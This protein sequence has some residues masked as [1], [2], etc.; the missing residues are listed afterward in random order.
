[1]ALS[2]VSY[3]HPQ[4]KKIIE[5]LKFGFVEENAE[6]LARFLVKKL[7][8]EK[9]INWQEYLFIPIPLH[10]KRKN[11]RGF[12]QTELLLYNV[13]KIM[14]EITFVDILERAK[15]TKQQALLDKTKR[16]KNLREAF[17]LKPVFFGEKIVLVDDVITTGETIL[18]AVKIFREKGVKE[19][20]VLSVAHG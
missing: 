2:A 19:I 17:S 7:Q 14:P 16:E 1:M 8:Q 12:N 18:S 15:N 6:V 5:G 10:K 20:I 13:K 4:I 3:K 11:W 9:N